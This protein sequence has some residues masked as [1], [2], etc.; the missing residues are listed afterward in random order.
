MTFRFSSLFI[1][2]TGG[3]GGGGVGV[4]GGSYIILAD[5]LMW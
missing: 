1:C 5:F 3:G 2:L 4:G